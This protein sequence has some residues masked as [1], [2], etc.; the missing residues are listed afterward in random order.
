MDEK[1]LIDAGNRM[2]TKPEELK[3]VTILKENKTLIVM[4]FTIH[5]GLPLKLILKLTEG[6]KELVR[7]LYVVLI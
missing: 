3:T 4:L 2:L 5:C 1:A 6:S 7:Y